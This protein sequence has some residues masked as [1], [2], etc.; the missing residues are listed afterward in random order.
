MAAIEKEE[1][2]MKNPK[3]ILSLT[4]A[5][6]LCA[7]L[8]APAL[9]AEDAPIERGV[10]TY[11]EPIAPQ[12]ED[13]RSFYSG[14]AAVKRDGKW[15][16][17]DE[18]NNVVIDFQYDVAYDFNE[19]YAIVGFRK[20]DGE[21]VDGGYAIYN[22]GFVDKAGQLTY[23]YGEYGDIL[24]QSVSQSTDMESEHFLFHNGVVR[25]FDAMYRADGHPI[26]FRGDYPKV[27]GPMNE[28]LVPL[29]LY[30][31]ADDSY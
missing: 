2:T 18:D 10:L 27:V 26:S 5:L 25:V 11:T 4:L 8:S 7:G 30:S 1:I 13:A 3:R 9:A 15:G 24:N 19:G 6:T 21:D 22:L 31:W 17:I 16:Y 14:L 12:Y 28:G 29:L 23:L 20:S